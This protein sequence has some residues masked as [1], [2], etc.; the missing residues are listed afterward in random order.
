[1]KVKVASHVPLWDSMDCSLPRLLCPLNSPGTNTIH[2]LLQGIFLTQGLNLSLL[3]CR[4]TVKSEPPG[5]P[6]CVQ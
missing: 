5:K 4:Q 2:S 3:H 6:D 1:M